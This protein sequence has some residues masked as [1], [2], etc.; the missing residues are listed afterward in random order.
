MRLYA[1]LLTVV[2]ALLVIAACSSPTPTTSLQ[3]ASSPLG[4]PTASSTPCLYGQVK[5][6]RDSGIFQV[7][8]GRFYSWATGDMICF[9]TAALALAAGFR[10]AD[11]Q[12]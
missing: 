12:R 1:K 3:A 5:A 2:A 4:Q 10:P 6:S 11:Q 9:D 7:P 8:S